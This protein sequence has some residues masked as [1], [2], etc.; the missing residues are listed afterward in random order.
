[1]V[2]VALDLRRA[3][4]QKRCKGTNGLQCD[5]DEVHSMGESSGFV[6]VNVEPEVDGTALEDLL[7]GRVD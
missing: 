1:M 7:A 4:K 6:A 2:V 3:F 5:E